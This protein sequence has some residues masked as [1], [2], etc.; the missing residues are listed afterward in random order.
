MLECTSYSCWPWDSTYAFKHFWEFT[1]KPVNSLRC[2]NVL[3]LVKNTY[4]YSR[5]TIYIKMYSYISLVL[6][7]ELTIIGYIYIC[8]HWSRKWNVTIWFSKDLKIFFP[9]YFI[10]FK[11]VKQIKTANKQIGLHRATSLCV[12]KRIFLGLSHVTP[13]TA[14]AHMCFLSEIWGVSPLRFG[15]VN[16]RPNSNW[17]VKLLNH[18]TCK[19]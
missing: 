17:M 18:S 9:E 8:I 3:S 2:L 7:I 6:Q 16:K 11:L 15:K 1:S 10:I 13:L 14:R 12:K 4:I 19:T 5:K